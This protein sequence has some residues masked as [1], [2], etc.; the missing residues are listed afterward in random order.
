MSTF[1]TSI[2]KGFQLLP[3]FCLFLQSYSND[4]LNT[5]ISLVS[6]ALVSHVLT[7]PT[8][9]T[10]ENR[11][12]PSKEGQLCSVFRQ[13]KSRTKPSDGTQEKH[14]NKNSTAACAYPADGTGVT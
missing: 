2:G 5:R 9:P 10:K 7:A 4:L 12:K 6:C 13:V 11:W 8:S 3:R 14:R 1:Q